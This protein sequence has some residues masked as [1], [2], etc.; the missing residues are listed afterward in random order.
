MEIEMKRDE[1]IEILVDDELSN[2]LMR[3][4]MLYYRD[5]R[6]NDLENMEDNEIENLYNKR[7]LSNVTLVA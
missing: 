2:I 7:F 4:L 3:D 6:I 5:N 1:L